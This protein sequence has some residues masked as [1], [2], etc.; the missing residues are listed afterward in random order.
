LAELKFENQY[1][2]QFKGLKEGVHDFNFIITK[3][4]FLE[5]EHLE[6]Q[7]G[8][9]EVAVE[10]TKKTNLLDLI[11]SFSGYIQVQCD[12]CLDYFKLPV[13]FEDQLLV[14]LAENPN[15]TDDDMVFLYPDESKLDLK[16]YLYEFISLSIPYRKVHPVLDNGEPGCDKEMLKQLKSILFRVRNKTCILRIT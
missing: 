5:F 15:D 6:A 9:L 4:F 16:H 2:I 14:K 3:P 1:I 10:V 12:R 7:D 8:N 11:I 13:A